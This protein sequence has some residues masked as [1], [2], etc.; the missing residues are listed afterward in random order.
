MNFV[1]TN[2]TELHVF[3][4]LIG[5]DPLRPSSHYPGTTAIKVGNLYGRG[6]VGPDGFIRFGDI[7]IQ[8][9]DI[10]CEFI[11]NSVYY[12]HERNG[13]GNISLSLSANGSNIYGTNLKNPGISPLSTVLHLIQ[14][15]QIMALT[16]DRSLTTAKI[17]FCLKRQ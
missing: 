6:D 11:S 13:E 12:I 1:G 14:I 10:A 9:D 7:A 3:E 16:L 8:D 5:A 4:N 17:Y 15:R 2:D